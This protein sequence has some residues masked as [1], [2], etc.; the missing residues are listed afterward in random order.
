MCAGASPSNG[1][2]EPLVAVILASGMP[3]DVAPSIAYIIVDAV[4]GA[5]LAAG[6]TKRQDHRD[7]ASLRAAFAIGLDTIVA[8]IAARAEP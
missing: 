6:T 5:A 8:G 4:H 2:S 3:D 1:A 7:P